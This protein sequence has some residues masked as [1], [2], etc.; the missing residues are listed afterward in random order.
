MLESP[1]LIFVPS[2][3]TGIAANSLLYPT[4]GANDLNSPLSLSS[5]SKLTEKHVHIVC[6]IYSFKLLT[7]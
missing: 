1:R 6:F 3:E 5:S 7:T 2:P 4:D